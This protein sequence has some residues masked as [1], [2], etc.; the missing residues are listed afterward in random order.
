VRQ[1]KAAARP[2][3]LRPPIHSTP[4]HKVVAPQDA[5]HRPLHQV[6]G[7]P[8]G[9]HGRAV[10][11]AESPFEQRQ[12]AADTPDSRPSKRR[13]YD[14]TPPSKLGYAQS[15]FGASLNLSGVPMSSAPRRPPAPQRQP[16]P[17]MF[18]SPQEE[19]DGLAAGGSF[20]E[21]PDA[22]V[23]RL[24][25]YGGGNAPSCVPRSPIGLDRSRS[26]HRAGVSYDAG[27]NN[28]VSRDQD[29][30]IKTGPGYG[31]SR[32][33][34]GP[35]TAR[36]DIRTSLLPDNG[37]D[38]STITD[39][40]EATR[41]PGDRRSKAANSGN[42]AVIVLDDDANSMPMTTSRVS[43]VRDVVNEVAPSK[44]PPPLP[45]KKK[46]TTKR[47]KTPP[48]K[49]PPPLAE[50]A[51]N[52]VPRSV[53]G[54]EVGADGEPKEK[55]RR[56][57]LRLK[58]RQKRGLLVASELPKRAKRP[59]LQKDLSDCSAGRP[60][61]RLAEPAQVN[62]GSAS[63]LATLRKE[64]PPSPDDEDPFASSPAAPA[65]TTGRD[66]T[67]RSASPR[68][69]PETGRHYPVS[70]VTSKEKGPAPPEDENLFASSPAAPAKAM[71]T[72][73]HLRPPS[74]HQK[75][76][77][78]AVGGLLV[79]LSP[80]RILGGPSAE[81][82]SK[83]GDERH[84]V[85]A[86]HIVA[87]DTDD[88]YFGILPTPLPP[89][90][91]TVRDA[92]AQETGLAQLPTEKPYSVGNRTRIRN[93]SRDTHS[94]SAELPPHVAEARSNGHTRGARGSDRQTE[95]SE[96]DLPRRRRAARRVSTDEELPQ[97]P[98]GPRLARLGRNVKSKEVIGYI[99]FSSPVEDEPSPPSPVPNSW[100]PESAAAAFSPAPRDFPPQVSATDST[101]IVARASPPDATAKPPEPLELKVLAAVV[102]GSLAAGSAGLGSA[103]SRRRQNSFPDTTRPGKLKE[104]G[105]GGDKHAPSA[106]NCQASRAKLAQHRS[107]GANP[108]DDAADGSLAPT[109]LADKPL[110]LTARDG[111]DLPVAGPPS[112]NEVGMDVHG[113]NDVQPSAHQ[114]DDILASRP[115]PANATCGANNTICSSDGVAGGAPSDELPVTVVG[116]PPPRIVNPATRG[117]KAALKS[118][119][120]GQ[121][122]QSILP[123][124]EPVPARLV[125]RSVP[126]TRQDPSGN[127]RPK[128]K[129]T[130]PG[131]VTIKGG[132]PWSREAHDLLE[133]GRPPL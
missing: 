127:E 14:I 84:S 17:E 107:D 5:R 114:N 102:P 132:G 19:H 52:V 86:V 4:L 79:N 101:S 8:T 76:S 124:A 6:I 33:F 103:S 80:R 55:E 95:S 123:P 90:N 96:E 89:P 65:R 43:K 29:R 99:P 94:T 7:T 37:P 1:V 116:N 68:H 126:E 92:T 111:V 62:K 63:A 28:P 85:K 26:N 46:K 60:S 108:G 88:E 75:Q 67:L 39:T 104:Q 61:D 83:A 105:S 35:S 74:P 125:A 59:K 66:H 113:K 117:R 130:F 112:A 69:E 57:E 15:L 115:N 32:H 77:T 91:R 129:M 16:R 109:A 49:S 30:S 98:I 122:P 12:K 51:V 24:G 87:D 45:T 10:V 100:G 42:L 58:S 18:S 36:D 118:H 13:K 128:R 81:H 47:K 38:G 110:H 54:G 23:P 34:T 71:R 20:E 40:R 21:I 131:F 72:E 120:A 106:A 93:R 25:S 73:R 121:V 56:T 119:A 53:M 41:E 44:L 133:R 64:A 82:Q 48:P 3:L 27:L 50:S 31:S 2:S 11:P 70:S 9:H 78:G 22:S 97:V